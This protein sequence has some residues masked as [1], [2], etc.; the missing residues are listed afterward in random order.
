MTRLFS[1]IILIGLTATA[2]A[3]VNNLANGTLI[4]HYMPVLSYCSDPPTGGWCAA[5][6][7]HAINAFEE[8]VTRIDAGTYLPAS[9][10]ILAAWHEEKS[11]CGT[12]FGFGDYNGSVFGF[13]DH[14]PCYP[15]GGLEI[16]TPGWPGPNEGIAFVV[17]GDSW[18]GNFV[19]VYWFG[20][21][22]YGYYGGDQIPLAVDPA[23]GFAGTSNCLRPPA[24]FEA[25]CLGALG[26]NTNGIACEDPGAVGA[27][28]DPGTGECLLLLEDE[29]FALDLDFHPEWTV[30]D[31][32]PCPSPEP[33][34]VCC[35]NGLCYILTEE[36]CGLIQGEFR[37]EVASCEPNPCELPVA[38]CCVGSL[39]VLVTMEECI[40][41]SGDWHPDWL[42]CDPNPCPV[43]SVE[44]ISWGRIKELFR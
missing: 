37:P 43:I 2:G 35:L 20:G 18:S 30:C 26:I 1:A 28:C 34:A 24:A 31:P 13:V 25:T 16:P 23:T 6:A 15:E 40:N 8:Q 7:S 41:Y 29:C 19:P 27:C 21:Y 39:C 38:A 33:Q 5:Y 12:E 36:E 32:N 14:A 11:W 3:D 9:W 22:A 17:S 4:V 10:Y 42:V 44:T